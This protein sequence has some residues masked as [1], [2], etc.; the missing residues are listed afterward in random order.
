[1]FLILRNLSVSRI[2]CHRSLM[3]SPIRFQNN[4][5]S[6]GVQEKTDCGGESKK[7][8]KGL[9]IGV[10]DALTDNPDVPTKFTKTGEKYNES[11][12]GR[13]EE[14]LKISGPLPKLGDA[15]LFFGLDHE[16][17][18]IAVVGLG[19]QCAGYNDIEELEEEKEAIRIGSAIGSRRLQELHMRKILID[20]FG[21]AESAAEGS[22]LAVWVY[23]ELKKA[24]NRIFMPMLELYDSCDYTGWH[25]GLEKAAA[26]NLARQLMDTPA[27]IMTPTSFAQNAVE[28][29]CKSGINVEVK[30]QGWAETQHMGAFLSV[31][32]GSCEPPIFLEISYYGT[33]YDERP[34]V[35]IGSGVTYDSGG[36]CLKQPY[37]LVH[38][39]GKMGGAA[40]VVA[41]IRAIAHL[42][43]PIN[44]RGLIPLCENMPGCA[45]FKPGDIV[46]A[47]N[48]K[49][50]LIQNT[51]CES[52]LVVADSLIYSQNFWPRFI[53]DIS[54][55]TK[56]MRRTMGDAATGVF[57]NSDALWE[58]I[59][60]AG[61]HTGDRLWRMPLWNYYTRQ[62]TASSAVDILNVGEGPGGGACKAAAFLRQFVPCGEW[63]H[64]DTLGVM[65]SNG[66]D[67]PYLQAGMSGRPTRTLIEFIS[68][69]LCKTTNFWRYYSCGDPSSKVTKGLVLG[70]YKPLDKNA[71]QVKLTASGDK[72][73]ARTQGQLMNQIQISGLHMELG[74]VKL[75]YNLDQEFTTIA[76]VG[77][78]SE[79]LGYNENEDRDEG[80]EAIR[81]AAAR[82]SRILQN[83]KI[84]RVYIESFGHS[85]SAAEGAAMAVW[86]YQE[87][88]SKSKQLHVPELELYDCVDYS[89]WHIGLQK[90]AAQ[91]LARQLMDTPAN[92]MTPSTFAQNAV[93]ILCKSGI[94]VE[95]KVQG[96][97]ET[98]KMGGFLAIAKGSCESP[99]FLELSYYG[100][101]YEE[102]PIVLIGSGI[103]FDSGGLCLK[104]PYDMKLMRGD[105]AGAACVIAT[106]R[107]IA[108]LQL[109]INI[110]GLIPLCENMPG[111]LAFKPGDIVT[112]M[113]AKIFRLK[114]QIAKED[115]L[116]PMHSIM[117]NTSGLDS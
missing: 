87:L 1:M 95:I 4:A 14:L 100:T 2:R 3:L 105:M 54:V 106:T 10:Y 82:G 77:L 41:T 6:K 89:G 116:L 31:A 9:V 30:V 68:H 42:Q 23:Q 40:M 22:A 49:N 102:R 19:K 111:C 62:T 75:F 109:P 51:D 35:L 112:A 61:V 114:I 15:R 43:L 28:I 58:Q 25:I 32:R 70:V 83:L 45:A 108:H 91:N 37:E 96:W 74:D 69:M 59:R 115:L 97:A 101:N 26:Q 84:Q 38:M 76:M 60:M 107:A 16:F 92:I 104:K 78:G 20:S 81:V 73:N 63:M 36:L 33:N 80:K 66:Q 117:P 24:D 72:M 44:L 94:N 71:E 12:E 88:K 85:E 113:N 17:N 56:D 79:C 21:H 29:L 5:S 34:V 48:G 27:N 18:A 57:T 86:V 11:I 98:Q 46:T 47:M 90:A 7:N 50:I 93:E 64:L 65:Y 103:T 39:K 8:S 67:V 53:V 99:I 110:R 55:L 13:L 52:R